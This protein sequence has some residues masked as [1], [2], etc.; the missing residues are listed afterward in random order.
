VLEPHLF[1]VTPEDPEP[2]R[3]KNCGTGRLSLRTA[4]SGGAFIGCSN[5]PECRY[6]RPLAGETEAGDIASP[7]GR[8]LG[9]DPNGA[10]VTLRKGPYGLYV[11]LG[12]AEGSQK[13]KRASL[14][15]GMDP[16][17][18]D[19]D[20]ALQLLSLPRPIGP[21]PDDGEMIEAGI[22]RF[23]PYVRHGKTY[24]SIKD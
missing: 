1:P 15:K 2:R 12:E 19:L 14:P 5:Y 9:H 22:G 24:A 13:P 21:H 11:Q 3:C 6:T 4:R 20:R 17:S 16:D 10:A 7:D 8:L 23:G 18:V